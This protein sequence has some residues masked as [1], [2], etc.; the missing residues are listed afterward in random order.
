MYE[1]MDDYIYYIFE[2]ENGYNIF[3]KDITNE[4][5][6]MSNKKS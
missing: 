5:L 3:Y 6:S 1:V 4:W 2:D